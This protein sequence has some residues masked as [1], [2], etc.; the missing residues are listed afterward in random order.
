MNEQNPPKEDIDWRSQFEEFNEFVYRML[1]GDRYG[2]DKIEERINSNRKFLKNTL[3]IIKK[4]IMSEEE[5]LDIEPIDIIEWINN[6]NALQTRYNSLKPIMSIE[7]NNKTEEN[8]D[9]LNSYI[10]SLISTYHNIEDV[11]KSIIKDL[12][13]I[14]M[15]H[16]MS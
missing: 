6:L 13:K 10:Q 15:K 12:N 9:K 7:K 2:S 11:N 1:N 4:K 16:L 8:I 5:Y 3:P 14:A